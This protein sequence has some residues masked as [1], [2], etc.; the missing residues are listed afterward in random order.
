MDRQAGQAA[1]DSGDWPKAVQHFDAFLTLAG[2][3]DPE[4]LRDLA[5]AHYSSGRPAL[6]IE[7]AEEAQRELEGKTNADAVSLRSQLEADLRVYRAD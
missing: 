6:A 7:I 2:R 4:V 1:T 5:F 3:R